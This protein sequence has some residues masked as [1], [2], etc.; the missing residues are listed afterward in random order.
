MPPG[1][2]G[3]LGG[4]HALALAPQQFGRRIRALGRRIER[5]AEMLARMAQADAQAVVG[6]QLVVKLIDDGELGCEGGRR[7]AGLPRG[8]APASSFPK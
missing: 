8:S 6:E 3:L 5:P 2:R 1:H 7:F 4:E